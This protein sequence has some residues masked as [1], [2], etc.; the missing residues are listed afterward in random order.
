M[1]KREV[2]IVGRLPLG[3]VV[4]EMMTAGGV[5]HLGADPQ[6]GKAFPEAGAGHFPEIGE[7]KGL[8]LVRD[9]SGCLDGSFSRSHSTHTGGCAGN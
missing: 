7:E 9:I 5:L 2:G 4:F 6:E 1:M 8:C 3:V